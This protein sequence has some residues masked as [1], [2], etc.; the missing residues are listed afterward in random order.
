MASSMLKRTLEGQ[1]SSQ[2]SPSKR[3]SNVTRPAAHQSKLTGRIT[4]PGNQAM[5]DSSPK[6]RGGGDAHEG[7]G[8]P[9]KRA[10]PGNSA[11]GKIGLGIKNWGSPGKV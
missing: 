8:S 10:R 2:A 5:I 1:K 9:S 3:P 6:R 11:A 7:A 4:K